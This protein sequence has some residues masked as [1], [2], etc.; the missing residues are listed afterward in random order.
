MSASLATAESVLPAF[1]WDEALIRRYDLSGPRY[2]S[3]PTAVEFTPD[4]RAAD[5]VGAAAAE[6]H[7]YTRVSRPG[8]CEPPHVITRCT[9]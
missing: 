8:V 4:F 7:S 9:R 6:P 5:M 3:Y 2:T 1:T